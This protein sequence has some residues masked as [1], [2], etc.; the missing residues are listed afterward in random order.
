LFRSSISSGML[1]WYRRDLI[2]RLP[3]PVIS[4]DGRMK[5][6]KPHVKQISPNKSMNFRYTT[7]AIT[8]SPEPLGFVMLC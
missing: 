7:A 3:L 5:H 4:P 8:I 1:S 6:Q 2:N